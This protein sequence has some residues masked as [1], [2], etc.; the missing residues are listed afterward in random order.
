MTEEKKQEQ[1]HLPAED[2]LSE[3]TL[4]VECEE[5]VG[6]TYRLISFLDSCAEQLHQNQLVDLSDI[7]AK[8]LAL[9]ERTSLL[10]KHETVIMIDPLQELMA[11]MEDVSRLLGEKQ[12]EIKKEM[13]ESEHMAAGKN[14]EDKRDSE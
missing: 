8:V 3:Q 14:L 1:K 5:L 10:P 4:G 2:N 13:A 11:K 6:A 12:Q 7:E 9:C